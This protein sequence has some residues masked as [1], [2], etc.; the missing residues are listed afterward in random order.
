MNKS[1]M[2]FPVLSVTYLAVAV[3]AMCSAISINK[4][5]LFGLSAASLFISLGDSLSSIKNIKL[6]NN[7]YNYLL[8]IT[9]VFLEE[10]I[11]NGFTP[12]GVDVLAI[13]SSI[14]SLITTPECIR[15]F[16]YQKTKKIKNFDEWSLTLFVIAIGCFIIIPF[17][18]I[19]LIS[20]KTSI[21]TTIFA[22]SV[23]CFNVFLSD[24]TND[25]ISARNAFG[26]DKQSLIQL[27]F[28]DYLYYFSN[29]I[30][31]SEQ[32]VQNKEDNSQG[33]N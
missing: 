9:S 21:Y 26:S 18:S 13:K 2:I 27:L 3:L 15:P 32:I 17:T 24:H 16:E 23:M 22:F 30:N 29:K 12:A 8:S 1:K 5:F 10:K 28:P 25:I 14:D 4:N 11:K 7:D 33:K 31:N 20:E 19:D 6:W